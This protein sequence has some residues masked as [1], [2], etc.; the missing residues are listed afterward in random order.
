MSARLKWDNLT[1]SQMILMCGHIGREYKVGTDHFLM[2][3][4]MN[5]LLDLVI[6]IREIASYLVLLRRIDLIFSSFRFCG[7]VWIYWG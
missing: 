5:S 4:P 1:A 6:S 7:A 2:R 3:F